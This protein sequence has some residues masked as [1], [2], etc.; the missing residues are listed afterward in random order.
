MDD[1]RPVPFLAPVF[2]PVADAIQ[3][4]VVRGLLAGLGGEPVDVHCPGCGALCARW[5]NRRLYPPGGTLGR[6]LGTDHRDNVAM[7]CRCGKVHH[8]SGQGVYYRLRKG[9]PPLGA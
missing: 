9:L 5:L 3:R 7:P 1:R 4:A 6:R 8:S 2:A